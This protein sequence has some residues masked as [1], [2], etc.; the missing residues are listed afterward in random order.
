MSSLTSA[1]ALPPAPKRVEISQFPGNRRLAVTTSW[2]D[3]TI[4]DRP[5]VA[6]MNEYLSAM[7]DVIESESGYIDK[8]IG[9]SIVP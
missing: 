4:H 1:P 7:T 5:L 8:Y 3:G 9:D 2:D 6:F